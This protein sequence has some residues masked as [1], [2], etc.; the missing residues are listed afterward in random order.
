MTQILPDALLLKAASAAKLRHVL[1]RPHGVDITVHPPLRPQHELARI[2]REQL[3]KR[4]L[5]GD[6][7]R[8]RVEFGTVETHLGTV[9]VSHNRG[10]DV[11][12]IHSVKTPLVDIRRPL[13]MAI[14]ATSS[15][16]SQAQTDEEQAGQK[17]ALAAVIDAVLREHDD[18]AA[19]VREKLLNNEQHPI[20]G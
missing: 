9:I 13:R 5:L 1:D 16:F 7:E 20:G 12:E 10:A 3:R 17:A 6:A 19:E 2:D 11:V 8:E 4:S 18:L 15:A 14:V